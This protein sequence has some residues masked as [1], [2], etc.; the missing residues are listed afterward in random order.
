ML[1]PREMKAST[2]VRSQSGFAVTGTVGDFNG[3]RDHHV[4]ESESGS[5]PEEGDPEIITPRVSKIAISRAGEG[6]GH[7]V[8]REGMCQ[9]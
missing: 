3:R 8:G 4:S 9:V 5:E 1:C 7:D 6:E 2:G